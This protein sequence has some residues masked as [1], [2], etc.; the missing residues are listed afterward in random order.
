MFDCVE[1][2]HPSHPGSLRQN[3]DFENGLDLFKGLQVLSDLSFPKTCRACGRRYENMEEFISRTRS[4][5]KSTGL[6][7]DIDDDGNII[8]ELFR[9]CI[10][11]S[12]LMDE[13]ND[14]R[15]LSKNGRQRREKFR[16]ILERM[17][18]TGYSPE[19]V[20]QEL[21]NIICGRGSE[22]FKVKKK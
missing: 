2:S 21:L 19:T 9:N 18:M 7:E 16:E 17:V 12:T 13:F 6:K 11:G 15:D 22:L 20:R 4:L 14:R 5:R 8:V 10:C 3:M 1:L